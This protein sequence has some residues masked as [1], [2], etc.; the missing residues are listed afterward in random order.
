MSLIADYNMVLSWHFAIS[1]ATYSKRSDSGFKLADC[2]PW[3][4]FCFHE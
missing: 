1:S 3:S 4:C 2:Q